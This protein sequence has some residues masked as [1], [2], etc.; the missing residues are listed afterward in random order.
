MEKWSIV[1][2]PDLFTPS[3]THIYVNDDFQA[4]ETLDIDQVRLRVELQTLTRLPKTKAILF[5]FK[6]YMYPLKEIKDE[7]LGPQVAEA[8]EGL[9][10]GNAP[11]MWKYK[12]AVRWGKGVCDYLN[13]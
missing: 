1:T 4:D 9:K 6:T 8:I 12:G 11:G 10:K 2:Q 7:G 13:A 3:G 5:S